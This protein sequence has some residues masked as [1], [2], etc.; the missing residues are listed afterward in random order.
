M[1][2]YEYE[3]EARL[4][5]NAPLYEAPGDRHGAATGRIHR[6]RPKASR[7]KL[8]GRS[9]HAE[10]KA[11][12]KAATAKVKPLT[13]DSFKVFA[14]QAAEVEAQRAN[15]TR[16]EQLLRQGAVD[17]KWFLNSASGEA[18]YRAYTDPYGIAWE[19]R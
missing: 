11:A 15:G 17:Y 9:L 19:E 1:V 5:L 16:R 2:H 8:P 12:E 4:M 14:A 7:Q 3:T 18:E 13:L 6:P 10:R